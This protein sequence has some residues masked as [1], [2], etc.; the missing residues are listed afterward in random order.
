MLGALAYV[1]PAPAAVDWSGQ[2][3]TAANS[4]SS[5]V[6]GNVLY[7][8]AIPVAFVGFKVVKKLLAKIA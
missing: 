2:F 3:Q 7:L 8:L 5:I 4:A 1:D 6:T